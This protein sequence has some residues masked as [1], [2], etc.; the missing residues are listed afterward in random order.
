MSV[1]AHVICPVVVLVGPTA[2]GKTALSLAIAQNHGCEIISMDSMQVYRYMD[3]GTAKASRQERQQVP[4]H[5]I[6]IVD[7][8]VQYDAACFVR[9]CLEAIR[10]IQTRGRLPLITG[11]TGMYLSALL[12]GIFEAMPIDQE[13]RRHLRQ[14][15]AEEGSASLHRELMTVDPETAGRLHPNDQQ[16]ILRGL[17]IHAASGIP[18]SVHL[19]RQRESGRGSHPR[20]ARLLLGLTCERELLYARIEQR[21]HQM[22]ENDFAGEVQ[23]LL[24]RG[25]GPDLPPMQAIGYRH[26][27]N[28][29][30]GTWDRQ[31]ATDHLIRDTRRY[32]KRQMT[33][34]RHQQEVQW[35][36]AASPDLAM[37][38]IDEFLKNYEK[39]SR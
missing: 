9:D 27:L 30:S 29:L 25:Y 11:G 19:R 12:D 34:F 24:D 4:H 3:I 31:T 37:D 23:G 18:W 6:D 38:Q 10:D 1:E 15:L 13:I 5:L 32:A 20:F 2:I 16:R 21:S 36:P 22:M 7:P 35:L 39:L 17:E 28:H 33:W 14:R 26:M 8:D